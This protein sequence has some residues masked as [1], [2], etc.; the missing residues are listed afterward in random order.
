MIELGLGL[1]EQRVDCV[2][3]TT[4]GGSRTCLSSLLAS[5]KHTSS[6]VC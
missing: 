5:S 3:V 1:G 6:V 2:N 4:L